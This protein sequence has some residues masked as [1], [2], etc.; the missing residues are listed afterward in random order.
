V[1]L[2]QAELAASRAWPK[3]DGF[4]L[5]ATREVWTAHAW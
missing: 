2:I 4:P 3:L 1:Q 5:V